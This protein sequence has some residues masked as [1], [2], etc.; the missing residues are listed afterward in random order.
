MRW[1]STFVLL[2]LL[3]FALGVTPAGAQAWLPPKGEASITFGVSSRFANE[4][5]DYQGNPVLPG[6]MTWNDAIADLSYGVTDRLSVRLGAPYVMSEYG[7][8]FPHVPPAGRQNYDDGQWHGTM[9]DLRAEVHFRVTTGALA[10]TPFLALVT[11]SHSYEY[12]AHA[13]A[14][15]DL[16]EG[17]VGVSVGRALDPLLSKAYAQVGFAFAVPEK[18]LGISHDR[19]DAA[20]DLGYF[21]T[22][23][24]TVSALG[25]WEKTYG[26]WRAGPDFPAPTDPLFQYHDQLVCTE[27]LRVGGGLSYALTGSLDV[28]LTGYTTVYARSDVNMKGVALAFTYGFSPSQIIKKRKGPN[29]PTEP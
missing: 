25:A 10:V 24:L 9:Q 12:F 28:G 1:M 22:P 18:V 17:Q 6:S 26:G 27:Y 7:G 4:H 19:T 23:R 8:Q 29:P 15:R 13:A 11:P 3:A 21:L 5:I 14:G 2:V 16:T 20:L